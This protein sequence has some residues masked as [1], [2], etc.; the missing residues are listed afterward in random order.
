MQINLQNV[1]LTAMQESKKIQK[2]LREKLDSLKA[3]QPNDGLPP[4]CTY[5]PGNCIY[6]YPGMSTIL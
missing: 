5:S 1:G 2:M 3:V 4:H 6:F